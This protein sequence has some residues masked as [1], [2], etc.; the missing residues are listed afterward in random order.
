MNHLTSPCFYKET[1]FFS[2]PGNS[3]EAVNVRAKEQILFKSA[4]ITA[5]RLPSGSQ[6][7]LGERFTS[8]RGQVLCLES[9]GRLQGPRVAD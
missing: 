9:W 4:G 5:D 3:L 2:V 1:S 7:H 8:P 6:H